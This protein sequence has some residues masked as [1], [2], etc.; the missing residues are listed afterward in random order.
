MKVVLR[1]GLDY[2]NLDRAWDSLLAPL[3]L[4][5]LAGHKV[6]LKPNLML[7][8]DPEAATCT[9]PLFV[10]SLAQYLIERGAQ[11]SVGDS[12]GALGLTSAGA[13]RIGLLRG[14]A[15]VGASFVDF[16]HC[17]VELVPLDGAVLREVPLP[18]PLLEADLRINVPKL[19]SHTLVGLSCAVKNAMGCLPGAVKPLFHAR[20][21]ASMDRL[22]AMLADI[23]RAA[24]FDCH[25]VDA[26][27][28][29]QGGGSQS[30]TPRRL[31]LALAGRDPVAIDATA[32]GLAGW[33]IDDVPTIRAAQAAGLGS[34]EVVEP[35][36]PI[37]PPLQRAGSDLKRNRLIGRLSYTLR[38]RAVRPIIL[39]QPE[40]AKLEG[41]IEICPWNALVGPPLRIVR[42][43]CW[44]CLTCAALAPSGCIGL[45]VLRPLR[46]AFAKRSQGLAPNGKLPQP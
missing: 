8:V 36:E 7:A 15:Q 13:Q 16:D 32:A 11:V 29:R 19:K 3:E 14:L 22:C 46:A 10:I 25:V 28:V 26:V 27:V 24:D 21:G 31:G 33:S 38:G 12:S 4:G 5:N 35:Y 9:H 17:P 30:G 42:R 1:D 6:L 23:C 37:D 39:R 20:F 43:R 41:I 18:R 40:A 34:P 45:E 2:F 44:G